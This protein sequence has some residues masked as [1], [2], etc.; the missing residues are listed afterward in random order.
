MRRK[1]GEIEHDAKCKSAEGR[2]EAEGMMQRCRSKDAE[3]K[4]WKQRSGGKEGKAKK[5]R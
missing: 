4:K 5:W 3:A 1:S 2:D